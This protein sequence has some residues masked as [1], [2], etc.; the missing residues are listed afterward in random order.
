MYSVGSFSLNSSKVLICPLGRGPITCSL[1][2]GSAE[3]CGPAR[4]MQIYI[5]PACWEKEDPGGCRSWLLSGSKG[6]R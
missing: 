6:E 3:G 4:L 1:A 5:F 2:Q